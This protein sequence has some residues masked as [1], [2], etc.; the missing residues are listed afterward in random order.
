MSAMVGLVLVEDACLA[1]ADSPAVVALAVTSGLFPADEARV[2]ERLMTDYFQR[3]E[4]R[5]PRVRH[6]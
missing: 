4:H 1:G 5:G 2:I 6:R 3:Q